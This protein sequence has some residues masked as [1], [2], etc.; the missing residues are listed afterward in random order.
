[1]DYKYIEQLLERYWQCETTLQE[2]HILRSFFA[3]NDVPEHL[4]QYQ[5]LFLCEESMAEEHLSEDF[6]KRILALVEEQQVGRAQVVKAKKVRMSY[7]FAPFFK[8][9]AVVAIVLSISMAVQQAMDTDQGGNVTTLPPEVVP[10]APETAY[11]KTDDA[12]SLADSLARLKEQQQKP[13]VSTP[14]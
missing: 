5:T 3:Q 4:K 9:A 12:Q 6:D 8:A 7:R 14:N 11:D 2:E 13:A 1:M 10:A